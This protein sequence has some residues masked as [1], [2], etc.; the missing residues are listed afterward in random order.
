MRTRRLRTSAWLFAAATLGCGAT[1][2]PPTEITTLRILGVQKDKPYAEPGDEVTLSL[3]WNDGSAAGQADPPR[4]VRINWL[5]GCLNPP[6]DAYSGCFQQYAD[7]LKSLAHPSDPN[8]PFSNFK[9]DHGSTFSVHV[10]TD[11]DNHG[12]PV[13]HPSQD[14][15]LPLYGLSYVFFSVC[16]GTVYAPDPPDVHFPIH[17][18]G[19]DGRDVGPDDFII[20]YSAIYF[21][22]HGKNGEPYTNANPI[23]NGLFFGPEEVTAAT[24][25]GDDCLG[26]CDDTGCVNRPPL[27]DRSTDAYYC[28]AF[29]TLCLP[30]CPDDGD[31][32]KCPPYDL[33]LGID[34]NTFEEDTVSNDA[35]GTNYAEQMWIDYYSTRGKFHSTTKLLNDATSGYNRDNG[36]QYYAPSAKG[37]VSLWVV[38]HDNRGGVSWL[39]TTLVIR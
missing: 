7:Y 29:P 22:A 15:K 24:C 16:A 37:P 10:P 9:Y 11:A 35:Y 39:G 27:P 17:C 20:G 2:D 32:T 28:D 3:L 19:E 36:T 21:F 30:S 38:T 4:E 34:P 8:G 33:R 1:F 14:P 26:S 13:L 18:Q 25:S 5:G 31:P 6:G 23:T 12:M